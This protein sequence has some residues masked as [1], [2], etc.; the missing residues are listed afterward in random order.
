[1][2]K[3]YYFLFFILISC[4]SVS[5]KESPTIY[6]SNTSS[7]M[8]KNIEVRWALKNILSLPALS[9]GDSRTQSFYIKSDDDF[10]GEVVVSWYNAR[11]E[12]LSKNLVFRKEHLPSVSDKFAFSYA[13]LYF[14]QE[15]VEI[16]ISD[17][18]DNNG[19][20]KMMDRMMIK[21]K[22]EAEARGIYTACVPS[23]LNLFDCPGNG[24]AKTALIRVQTLQ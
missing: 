9:P 11:S 18:V 8:I 2:S 4:S 22:L 5:K 14:S 16:I 17:I 7:D 6:F 20:A 12:K 3:I 13:Q 21:Y 24:V 1:M 19:K 23:R 10:F 15:N